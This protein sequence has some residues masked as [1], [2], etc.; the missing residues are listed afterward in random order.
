M[1]DSEETKPEDAPEKKEEPTKKQPGHL[2]R[3]GMNYAKLVG[4]IT[5]LT[6]AVN[7][8]LDLEKKNALVYEALASKVNNMSAELSE[9][10]GQNQVILIFLSNQAGGEMMMDELGSAEPTPNHIH[11]EGHEPDE[12]EEHVEATAALPPPVEAEFE[13]GGV[14]VAEGETTVEVAAEEAVPSAKP[15][16]AKKR[17]EIQAFQQLPANLEDL[18]ELQE[19]IQVQEE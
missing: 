1:A 15:R 16:K 4:A 19:Q 17:V 3:N 13:E 6:A 2:R 7:G 12:P 10:K 11:S 9:I 14:A 5:A 8:Y 18:A